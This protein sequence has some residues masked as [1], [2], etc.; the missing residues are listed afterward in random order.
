MKVLLEAREKIERDL[1]E[2]TQR[3]GGPTAEINQWFPG[4]SSLIQARLATDRSL[5]KE[6][7]MLSA[8]IRTALGE[9]GLLLDIGDVQRG[10]KLLHVISDL[11]ARMYDQQGLALAE[12]KSA[13][14]AYEREY[15]NAELP[16]KGYAREVENIESFERKSLEE[17]S[18]RGP[19]GRGIRKPNQ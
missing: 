14:E 12:L 3:H 2:F 8:V 15:A 13:F 17:I 9:L 19:Y 16:P 5:E 18:N 7:Q 10:S 4:G 6:R 1:E 11:S